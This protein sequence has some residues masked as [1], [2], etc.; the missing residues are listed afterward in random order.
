[1]ACHRTTPHTYQV[2]T[3]RKDQ[4]HALLDGGFAPPPSD[5][6]DPAITDTMAPT[7]IEDKGICKAPCKYVIHAPVLQ[8][9]MPNRVEHT[10]A[11]PGYNSRLDA[12]LASAQGSF[13]WRALVRAPMCQPK[14]S[15]GEGR[16]SGGG[17]H[18]ERLIPP[19]PLPHPLHPL[20]RTLTQKGSPPPAS[21]R[22]P[23]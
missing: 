8:A 20:P 22:Q 3:G 17:G 6:D 11:R 19:R 1:M 7:I 14:M 16:F 5:E 4:G 9:L 12:S 2:D 15:P 23:M 10:S 21:L 18:G 13:T